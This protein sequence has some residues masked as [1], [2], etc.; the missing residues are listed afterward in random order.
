[1]NCSSVVKKEFLT[2]DEQFI[3][4]MNNFL[5][6]LDFDLGVLGSS[7]EAIVSALFRNTT[8]D[9]VLCKNDW[10][11]NSFITYFTFNIRQFVVTGFY[12]TIKRLSKI[13]PALYMQLSLSDKLDLEKEE[14]ID[15]LYNILIKIT[16]CNIK[17]FGLYFA[18]LDINKYEPIN[19][20][21]TSKEDIING[22]NNYYLT[23]LDG[24]IENYIEKR[25]ILSKFI[26]I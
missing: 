20:K 1:M 5:H 18:Y 2:A 9:F 21:N 10:W 16:W 15:E 3:D 26:N 4:M 7:K 19:Q 12:N 11:D 6:Y 25:V 17:E 23:Q 22:I 14:D 24:L 8:P 13:R